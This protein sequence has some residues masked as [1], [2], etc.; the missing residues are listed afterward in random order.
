MQCTG[1]LLNTRS[2]CIVNVHKYVS[3]SLHFH[4]ELVY[5][6][7]D[8]LQNHGNDYIDEGARPVVRLC[9]D[10]FQVSAQGKSHFEFYTNDTVHLLLEDFYTNI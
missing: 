8:L 10:L 7:I 3:C 5:L 6:R 2:P 1:K 4:G 9:M